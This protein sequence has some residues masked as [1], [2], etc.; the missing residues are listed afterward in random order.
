MKKILFVSRPI[1]PPW[2]EASKNFAYN[3]SK[4]TALLEKDHEIHIMTKGKLEN[5]PKNVICD[6]VYT[7]SEKDFSTDQKIR[8]LFFQTKKRSSFDI[9]QYFFTP[10]KASS[11]LIKNLLKGKSKTIQTIAT[12][13]EDLLSDKE[14]KS[15]MFGDV[16]TTYSEYAKNKLNSLGFNNVVKI[17]PGIDLEDY[18]PREKDEKL[19]SE[20]GFKKDDFIISFAGEYIR[21]GA[22]DTVIDGFIEV[23]KQIPS[24]RL[25]L[26]VRVKNEKD[27]KKKEEVIKQLEN[28]DI[29]EKVSFHDNW[30]GKMSDLY[31]LCD[32]SIFPIQN[33]HGKFDVP[34]VLVEAMACEKP[35]IISDI[36]ILKEFS[37]SN[38]SIEVEK[39]N[40]KQLAKKLIELYNN[41]G[42]AKELGKRAGRFA[43]ENFDIKKSAE[44]YNKIYKS[45]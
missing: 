38:N 31:N 11:F 35:V 43:Q 32:V 9:I 28:E 21:L 45:L 4:E 1:A 33:M 15:M 36:P 6:N 13:R 30:R 44:K 23:A 5:M 18:S 40:P 3:L 14:I 19:L 24:A 37:D 7:K 2:D 34:L 12:L 16:I 10:A 29:L 20:S 26:A 17:Y 41:P 22:M 8:S 27:T 42:K 39:E 25:S